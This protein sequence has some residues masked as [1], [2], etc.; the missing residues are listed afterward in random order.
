MQ[1]SDWRAFAKTTSACVKSLMSS[2]PACN[3]PWRKLLI[4][5]SC[6]QRGVV[7]QLLCHRKLLV[8]LL[9]MPMPLRV[10]Q[11]ARCRLALP[12]RLQDLQHR[13]RLRDAGALSLT[14]STQVLPSASVF[15]INI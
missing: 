3:T 6:T 10:T 7:T 11:A 15:D 13:V 12:R 1:S 4:Q 14:C 5:A 2:K 8:Q 9:A